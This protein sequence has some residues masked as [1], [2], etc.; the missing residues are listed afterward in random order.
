MAALGVLAP[1]MVEELVDEEEVQGEGLVT[2]LPGKGLAGA[3]VDGDEDKVVDV[4]KVSGVV[5]PP[6]GAV[7]WTDPASALRRGELNAEMTW[8]EPPASN[9]QVRGPGYLSGDQTKVPSPP[10]MFRPIA[11]HA[12]HR[13]SGPAFNLAQGVPSLAAHLAAHPDSFFFLVNWVLPGPPYRA[14]MF[15]FERQV[16]EGE[17]PKFDALWREFLAADDEQRKARLKYLPSIKRAPWLVM[18]GVQSLGAERPTMICRKL[19]PRFF[20]GPN[21]IEVDVDVASSSIAY[22]IANSVLPRLQSTII[23]HAFIL[24]GH[25]P[26]ELPE[27]VLGC[28]RVQWANLAVATIPID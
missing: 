1:P 28:L 11:V 17:D 7:D 25:A 4:D 2:T 22:T 27:R 6:C 15:A 8:A 24:E 18:Q 21:Y 14:A 12:V 5:D 13:A 10:A 3:A 16:P 26:E 19:Q 20:Q 9:F 23:E